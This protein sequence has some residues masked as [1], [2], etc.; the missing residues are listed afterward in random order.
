MTRNNQTWH[1]YDPTWLVQL[2]QA[3]HPD[4]PWLAVALS[5]C[6]HFQ[7]ESRAYL[8]FI[9]PDC[10]NQPGSAWQFVQNIQ[11]ND[12]VEGTIILD[13]LTNE[14]IGGA[15]FLKKLR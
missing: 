11:L 8:H 7:M 4:K 13:I 5:K 6:T 3:Q 15:E 14:R 1:P 2:A 9:A 10:P 12:P